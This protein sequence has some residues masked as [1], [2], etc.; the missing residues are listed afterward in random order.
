MKRNSI[1]SIICM[2]ALVMLFGCA[3]TAKTNPDGSPYWTTMTPNA[4]KSLHYEVGMAK[5]STPQLSLL[6]AESAAKDAIGRWAS[7]TVDNSLV[8]FVEE[9]G[10]TLKTQQVLSV[11]QNLSVQ[12]VN[13]ALRGVSTVERYTSPEGT[14]W[15]L[16]SYPIKNLKDAYKLQAQELE[17]KLALE[18]ANATALEA[19]AKLIQ[20]DVLIS[21][22][23][24]Q[25][26]SEAKD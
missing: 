4:T 25:L 9:A 22:L 14:V 26:E 21:Y 17:R 18:Q 24:S 10:E 6:R 23:E 2:F 12:T 16:C 15:V 20:A 8:T 13:I 11:L 5:Q 19:E 7:T 1:L 3:T